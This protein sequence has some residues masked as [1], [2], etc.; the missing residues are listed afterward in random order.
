M[1][2]LLAIVLLALVGAIGVATT[3]AALAEVPSAISPADRRKAITHYKRGRQLLALK[4]FDQA[5]AEL[6]ASIALMPSPNTEL[7]RAHALREL[8]RPAEAVAAY[9]RVMNE[10][11]DRIGLGQSRYQATLDDA[12]Q[13]FGKLRP[14]VTE[15]RVLVANAPGEVTVQFEGEPLAVEAMANE[16]AFRARAW[17]APGSGRVT[18]RHGDGDEHTEQ[19]ELPAGKVQT[20]EIDLA[21]PPTEPVEPGPIEPAPPA[22]PVE[23]ADF[24]V[25]PLASFI[26]AGVGVVGFGMFAIFG[27][28]SSS[29]AADLDECAPRCP[30]ALREDADA[31]Q[32]QQTVANVGLV[33]G[34][35]GLAAAGTIWL[36]DALLADDAGPADE[37]DGQADGM[38][39]SIGPAGV[40][41]RGTF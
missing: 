24:P 8:G 13:W 30:D 31:G 41:L 5:L 9:E 39:L 11:T 34:I 27:S 2:R 23:G 35:A 12:S 19:V 3:P 20:V 38:A 21:P 22:P 15:L 29:T 26:T 17:L 28:L 33:I 16:G 40:A 6:D 1:T 37:G 25:P 36:V 10:A 7:L 18:V 4:R 14:E 32:T